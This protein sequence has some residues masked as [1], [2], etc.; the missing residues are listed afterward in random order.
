MNFSEV[1][2]G[3]YTRLKAGEAALV[4]RQS[5]IKIIDGAIEDY[6]AE[7]G[8]MPEAADLERLGSLI[9]YEELTDPTRNK[10]SAQDSPIMS[11][12]QYARRREG[13]H[14]RKNSGREA[15]LNA[16]ITFGVDGKNH[17]IPTRQVR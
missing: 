7:R 9:L 10:M 5:R 11:D 6:F 3:L 17:R 14:Q 15:G 2:D 13:R 12:S 4:D 1:I 8:K 16:A